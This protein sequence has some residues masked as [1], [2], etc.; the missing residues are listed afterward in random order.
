MDRE[1]NLSYNALEKEDWDVRRVIPTLDKKSANLLLELISAEKSGKKKDVFSSFFKKLN[2]PSFYVD[3][4]TSGFRLSLLKGEDNFDEFTS[5]ID[6]INCFF[7]K[8]VKFKALHDVKT[9]LISSLNTQLVKSDNY[10]KKLSKKLDEL[11]KESSNQ[12]KGDILMANLN[13]VKINNSSLDLFNFYTNSMITIRLNPLLSPQKNAERY[14]RKSKNEKKEIQILSENIRVRQLKIGALKKK[15]SGIV[16]STDFK[17]LQN[18]LPNLTS[19]KPEVVLPYKEFTIDDYTI[20]VGKNAKHNDTLTL[21]I[22]KKDDLWLHAKDVSGSHV[23]VK[24]IPGKVYPEYIIVKASQLAAYYSKRKTDTICP[25]LY[26]PKKYVR[27]KK[28]T[29]AGT[30]FVEK[31]KVILVEPSNEV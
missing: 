26:T 20:L 28:G 15:L 18:Q 21:K 31:E 19:N 2:A 14:Y 12:H 9:K 7:N 22:A 5:P 16:D 4:S 6:A 30:M 24:Q 23:V 29:P 3:R 11:S 17:F 10:V 27:K 1:L 13:V 25:V 8:E